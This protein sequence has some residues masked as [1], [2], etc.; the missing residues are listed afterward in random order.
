MGNW[1]AAKTR[2]VL[3][4]LFR[5]G[6]QLK[7]ETGSHKTLARDGGPD[8]TFAFHDSKK[9]ARACRQASRNGRAQG[10]GS[11]AVFEERYSGEF[12]LTDSRSHALYVV[13]VSPDSVGLL[14]AAPGYPPVVWYGE[15]AGGEL[16]ERLW[17]L[18]RWLPGRAVVSPER[19]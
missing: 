17:A 1:P 14:F 7:R 10:R 3:A 13:T 11:V 6:W 19:L 12:R 18:R 9:S 15:I 16:R 5:I 4:A 2:H 8:F